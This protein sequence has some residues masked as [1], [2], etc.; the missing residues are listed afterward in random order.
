[1]QGGCG[2]GHQFA[3]SDED[4][5]HR[6]MQHGCPLCAEEDR[7]TKNAVL[8]ALREFLPELIEALRRDN[9]P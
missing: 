3:F 2:R 4:Q 5:F 1:M 9:A 7:R 8:A 6:S